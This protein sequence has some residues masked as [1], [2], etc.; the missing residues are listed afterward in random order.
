MPTTSGMGW[1][2]LS[3]R[4][5]ANQRLPWVPEEHGFRERLGGTVVLD[6]AGT[7]RKGKA[8]TNMCVPAWSW[9]TN[10]DKHYR[11]PGYR[12]SQWTYSL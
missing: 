6:E 2:T 4:H 7:A 10:K 3:Q 5:S 11:L 9:V 8:P 1:G 12:T